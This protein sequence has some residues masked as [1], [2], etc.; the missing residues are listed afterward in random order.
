VSGESLARSICARAW[1]AAAALCSTLRVCCWASAR[2][3]VGA[4]RARSP[5]CGCSVLDTVW[6]RLGLFH[7]KLLK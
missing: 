5:L 1:R 3:H 7:F 2:A 6:Q 4:P